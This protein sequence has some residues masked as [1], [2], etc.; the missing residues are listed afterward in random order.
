MQF[1]ATPS[2]CLWCA[3]PPWQ[4]SDGFPHA[5][6]SPILE[7]REVAC[8]QDATRVCQDG[9]CSL[10]GRTRKAFFLVNVR[11]LNGRKNWAWRADGVWASSFRSCYAVTPSLRNFSR[12]AHD[13]WGRRY[14]RYQASWSLLIVPREDG[15]C[16]KTNLTEVSIL[17]D[18]K[19]CHWMEKVVSDSADGKQRSFFFS[20]FLPPVPDRILGKG[21]SPSVSKTSLSIKLVILAPASIKQ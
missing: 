12:C 13:K 8:C 21:V 6:T 10:R 16:T 9:N 17:L 5:Q 7:T 3:A 15:Q 18:W 4:H 11:L 2:K 19:W 1:T 14:L 20:F